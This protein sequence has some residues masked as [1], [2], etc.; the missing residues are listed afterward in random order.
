MRIRWQTEENEQIQFIP[1]QFT[2]KALFGGVRGGGGG[3][4]E[5]LLSSLQ[6]TYT[7]KTLTKHKK[8]PK[9]RTGVSRSI[10]KNKKM[11]KKHKTYDLIKSLQLSKH[12]NLENGKFYSF[13]VISSFGLK[14]TACRQSC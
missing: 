9:F 8:T 6:L 3:G 5:A 4:E 11:Q 2:V 14:K 13:S 12:K 10:A 7:F 1:E